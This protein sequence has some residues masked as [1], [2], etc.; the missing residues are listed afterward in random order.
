MI[1]ASYE[2]PLETP[3]KKNQRIN[4]RSGRSFPSKRYSEWH[5]VASKILRQQGLP[6]TPISGRVKVEGF[7]V[8]GDHRVRDNNNSGA[9]I[10]D[11]FVD[12]GI[13]EDDRDSIVVSES[14]TKVG[15][16]KDAPVAT[17]NIWSLDD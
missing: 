6:E 5:R 10:L 13:L 3:S 14:W 17:I 1:L 12:V 7:F 2:I 15:I 11:L 8:R 9:S 4:T 16:K